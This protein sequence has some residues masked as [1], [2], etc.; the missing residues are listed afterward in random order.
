VK[1]V[2]SAPSFEDAKFELKADK[3]IQIKLID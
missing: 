2:L 3:V 1:P